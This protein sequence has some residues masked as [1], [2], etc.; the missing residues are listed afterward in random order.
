LRRGFLV[1]ALVAAALPF[2]GGPAGAQEVSRDQYQQL[3]EQLLKDPANLDLNLRFA[4][5]AEQRGDLEA[6]IGALER[7]LVAHPDSAPIRLRL[8]QLYARLGSYTMARAYLAP[9]AAAPNLPQEMQAQAQRLLDEVGGLASPHQ[10]SAVLFAGSQWQTD[11][12]AAPGSPLFLLAGVPTLVPSSFAKRPDN[13]VFGQATASYGYDL[14]TQYH[15]AI[16]VDGSG[17]GS[18][19]RRLHQLDTTLGEV[20]AGPRLGL[21][22][23]GDGGGNVKPYVLLDGVRLGGATYSY[24]YGGGVDIQQSFGGA[25]PRLEFDYESQQVG[26]HATAN[27]PTAP[28][29]AGRFDHYELDLTEPIG[30]FGSVGVGAI[31]NRQGARFSGYANNDYA[32]VATASAAYSTGPLSFGYPVVTSVTLARHYVTYDAP[33]PSVSPT[34]K[35]GDHRWQ[36]SVGEIVPITSRLSLAAVFYRDIDSSNVVN[37][38]YNNTSFLVG[39]QLKF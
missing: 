34:L 5:A 2:L 16:E 29:L 26:Y 3:L 36:V 1:A 21:G 31:D 7:I 15:D 14:G 9:L 4:D 39:P 23:V 25:W 12:G 22:R 27:Y 11:P 6:A 38:A 30:A 10:F 17:Y 37:Y 18:S 33:D 13:D 24:A 35:R 20:T 8:G 28:L 19:F 32:L